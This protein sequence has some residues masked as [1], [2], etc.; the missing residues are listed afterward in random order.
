MGTKMRVH[1]LKVYS[2]TVLTSLAG[3]FRAVVV[4]P[5]RSP[6]RSND[7]NRAD[8]DPILAEFFVK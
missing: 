8:G 5:S 7:L 1:Y 6:S 2:M 3:S 4:S